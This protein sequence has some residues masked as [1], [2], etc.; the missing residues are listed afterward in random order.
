MGKLLPYI[1][2]LFCISCSAQEKSKEQVLFK[3][4]GYTFPYKLEQAEHKIELP[5][6]LR[7]ISGLTYL[8]ENTLACVNDEEGKIYTVNVISGDISSFYFEKGGDYEGVER[9]GNT[10]WVVKS[11]GN[12]YRVKHFNT[13]KQKVKKFDTGLST[14]NDVEGLGYDPIKEKL[15]LACKGYPYLDKEGGRSHKAVY[16]FDLEEKKLKKKILLDIDLDD[17]KLFRKYHAFARAGSDI[18]SKIDPVK[19]DVSFQ[20]SGI[21]VRPETG[22]YYLIGSVG[23]LLIVLDREGDY[24]YVQKLD[25][26]TFLQPEGICFDPQGNLYISNEAKGFKATIQKF[27]K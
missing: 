12:L 22:N 25:P 24:L 14:A 17:I 26:L 11:N 20:P 13:S 21:A 4:E 1:L 23:K 8:K 6:Y 27:N 18:L 10:L 19:G 2:I 5:Y 16:A 9:V 3:K 7:E 15:L